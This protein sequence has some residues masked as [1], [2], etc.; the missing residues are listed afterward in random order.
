[1]LT[2]KKTTILVLSFLI[3]GL[4]GRACFFEYTDL[5]DPTEARYAS[6]PQEMVSSGNWVT[7]M[8]PM[9]EGMV[10]YL[11]K[12]P[13]HFWI[14]ALS[15]K[16]FGVQEAAARFPSLVATIG[17]LFVMY[18][19]VSMLFSKNEALLSLMVFFSSA[20]VFFVSG[21]SVIDVTLTL[22]TTLGCLFLYKAIRTEKNKTYFLVIASLSTALAFLTKGPVG[23]VLVILPVLLWSLIERDFS[24]LKKISVKI[25]VLTFSALV[26]PWFI[27]SEISN[28]GFLKYFFWNENIARYLF[29][30]YGDKYG[31][32]HVH[33]YGTSWY[34]FALS[35]FPW[36][37]TVFFL[38]LKK[39]RQSVRQTISAS[40]DLR[41]I[42]CCAIM[43]P[44][45]FTF[46]RQLHV[47]YIYPALP[48]ISIVIAVLAFQGYQ[49]NAFATHTYIARYKS[50]G[51][52][53]LSAVIIITGAILA[54]S[55]YAILISISILALGI[56]VL[57]QIKERE[58]ALVEQVL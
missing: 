21:A 58:H 9:P 33:P 53:L 25:P 8:L 22:F 42:V 49:K 40:A 11:G 51:L 48:F 27:V 43:A 20:L 37:L 15:Y 23:V 19:F 1:V 44:L 52:M 47:L 28:P 36:L 12:P 56:F 30:D 55:F 14:T 7:P 29:K 6:I 16:I 46:V 18:F 3:I 38:F 31:S 5:I 4:I 24:W 13:L 34:M 17:L 10:P 57:K 45:F 32:G 26:I 41:Y 2:S 50:R 35:F 39:V 54:F